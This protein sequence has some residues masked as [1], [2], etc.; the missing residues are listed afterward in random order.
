MRI[1]LT[2]KDGQ[3]GH[4]LQTYLGL[5][6]DLFSYGR[7]HLNLQ[8]PDAIRQ[9]IDQVR[10]DV[11]V[12]GA[13]Y[14]A[15]DRA[16]QEPDLAHA[17]NTVAPQVMA[18]AAQ[19]LGAGILHVSTDYVFDGK[20]NLPYREEDRAQPLG[21]YGQSK[22]LGEQAVQQGCDRHLVVRTAWVYGVGGKGNF[23]KTMVRLGAEREELRVVVD[24]VGTPTWTG[25]LAQAIGQ[26]I[27][28]LAPSDPTV[29]P[30]TGLYH[31]TNSGAISWYDFA[32]AILEEARV[33]GFPLKVKRVVPI[34][35]AEYPTA[36]QRPAYS[37]LSGQKT[38]S[39][40]GHPA[41][42]W[43]TG[44]RLM[45]GQLAKQQGLSS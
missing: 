3:L 36:A 44:L 32:V 43:Q 33:L 34:T 22:W 15:V 26:M 24:Q 5:D 7:D 18:T 13:A 29:A 20:H 23:V 2:G 16:E 21:V 41:P 19:D 4:D 35:T 42:H 6:H 9:L 27:H 31:F 14:T 40:L 45:L 25:D 39:L 28:H 11:I 30:V 12:N 10:P 37:V 1:L 8:D 17:I 38:A